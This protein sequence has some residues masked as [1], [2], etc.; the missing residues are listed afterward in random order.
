MKYA[1]ILQNLQ[2]KFDLNLSRIYHTDEI[3]INC[4][5]QT[6]YFWGIID[7]GTRMLIATHYSEKRN[8]Q[9]A[10]ML[11]LKASKTS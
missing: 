1:K 6:H 7:K 11:F 10:R 5:G 8:Y 2:D 3:F 4:K 9:S